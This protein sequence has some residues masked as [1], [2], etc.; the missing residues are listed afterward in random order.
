[1]G[2]LIFVK[3]EINLLVN[4]NVPQVEFH[5]ELHQNKKMMFDCAYNT[6][7]P[8][9]VYKPYYIYCHVFCKLMILM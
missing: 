7:L 6:M 1:M 4:Y 5:L 8:K 3:M 9:E 2:S